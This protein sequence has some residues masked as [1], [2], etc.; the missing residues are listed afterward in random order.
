MK[1]L[2]LPLFLLLCLNMLQAQQLEGIDH[3]RMASRANVVSYDDE[4]DIEHLRYD[5]SPY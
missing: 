4:N 2:S 1:R 3:L 5:H